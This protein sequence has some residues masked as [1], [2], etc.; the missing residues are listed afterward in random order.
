MSLYHCR[1]CHIDKPIEAFYSYSKRK[2]KAC[3]QAYND[4]FR[5]DHPELTAAKNKRSWLR[6]RDT[7][8]QRH[9]A[10]P[11]TVVRAP[12]YLE[13]FKA[14]RREHREEWNAKARVRYAMLTGKISRP[15]SC[16]HCGYGCKPQAHHDD[17]SKPLDVRWLCVSCHRR[18]HNGTLTDSLPA[19]SH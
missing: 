1:H 7:F 6:R 12:D 4:K 17:Y 3:I 10:K 13:K 9:R 14:Y 5:K 16:S 2:C 11:R 15:N 8:L 18:L 19:T